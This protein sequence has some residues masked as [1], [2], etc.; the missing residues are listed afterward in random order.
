[1]HIVKLAILSLLKAASLW[2]PCRV[3]ESITRQ[4][5]QFMAMV[6]SQQGYP[7]CLQRLSPGTISHPLRGRQGDLLKEKK[8]KDFY[9]EQVHRHPTF[10]RCRVLNG[11]RA[12]RQR[13]EGGGSRG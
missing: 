2:R 12:L 10:F 1:M 13:G 6:P 11:G 3:P 5:K 8:K 4:Q 7:S 9:L